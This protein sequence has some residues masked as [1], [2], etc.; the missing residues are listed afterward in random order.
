MSLPRSGD[1][2]QVILEQ[3]GPLTVMSPQTGRERSLQ[4]LRMDIDITLTKRSVCTRIQKLLDENMRQAA[5][6]LLTKRIL[7]KRLNK[8]GLRMDIDITLTK[9]S[10]IINLS[11][12]WLQER[13]DTPVWTS[14]ILQK[15]FKRSGPQAEPKISIARTSLFKCL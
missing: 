11:K 13:V 12:I 7:H 2:F 9:R 14:K 6:G 10:L 5:T 3:V 15:D 4:G 8:N 1:F